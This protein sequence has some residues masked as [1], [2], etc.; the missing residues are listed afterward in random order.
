MNPHPS[1]SIFFTTAL[2]L[3]AALAM[4][5]PVAAKEKDRTKEARKQTKTSIWIHNHSGVRDFSYILVEDGGEGMSGSA[6]MSDYQEAGRLGKTSG[7]D[8]VWANL[9]GKRYVILDKGVV[10]KVRAAMQ[11]VRALGEQQSALGDQQSRL[12]DRQSELGDRQ[13]ELGDKQSELGDRE[14]ELSEKIADRQAAG[15]STDDL[16]K[17]M[18]AVRDEAQRLNRQ[19]DDLARQQEALAKQQEPLSRQ[20]DALSAQSDKLSH[21]MNDDIEALIR[22]AVKSGLAVLQS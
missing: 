2:L 20:Q 13:S 4:Q 7:Q 12:G 10:G 19:Q 14:A 1:G 16:R 8:L 18:K 22:D 6:E 11:P 5:A 3:A 9:E 21:K 15:R 17:E